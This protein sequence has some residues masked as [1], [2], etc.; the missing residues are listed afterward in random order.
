MAKKKT[1]KKRLQKYTWK[2]GELRKTGTFDIDNIK[3]PKGKNE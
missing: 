1:K 2:D 3:K